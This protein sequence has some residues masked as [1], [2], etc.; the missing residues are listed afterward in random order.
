M[1]FCYSVYF[2]IVYLYY[3]ASLWVVSVFFIFGGNMSI[4]F[5]AE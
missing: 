4:S 2:F 3:I 1:K 5:G